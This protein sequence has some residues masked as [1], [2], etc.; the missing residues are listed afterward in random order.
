MQ[1]T[2]S[3][4][5]V[6]LKQLRNK[7][8]QAQFLMD[9]AARIVYGTPLMQSCGN[10]LRYFVLAFTI[11]DKKAEYLELSMGW[12]AVL[13]MDIEFCLDQNIIHYK[14]RNQGMTKEEIEKSGATDEDFISTQKIELCKIIARIDDD[15]CKWRVS[16][17]KG[18]T[19]AEYDRDNSNADLLEER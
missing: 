15:M 17:N 4:I 3:S 7:L 13:R 9:K 5:F 16:L 1:L 11:K 6:S 14:K 12:F 8:Y 10:A 19:I 18:K 2:K